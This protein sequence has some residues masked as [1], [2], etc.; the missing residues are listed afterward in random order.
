M[1]DIC[2]HILD[3]LQR[4]SSDICLHISDEQC[5]HQCAQTPSENHHRPAN[6]NQ[7]FNKKGPEIIDFRPFL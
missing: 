4:Y 3:T 1:S 7:R 6:T 5:A 2:T